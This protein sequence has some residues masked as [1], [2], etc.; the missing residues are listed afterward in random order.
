LPAG[1]EPSGR[2]AASA[3]ELE[4]GRLRP[5]ENRSGARIGALI[6]TEPARAPRQSRESTIATAL[7]R[8][9]FEPAEYTARATPAAS[10]VGSP[11]PTRVVFFVAKAGN[12]RST[13][14]WL[15]LPLAPL[16]GVLVFESPLRPQPPAASASAS[17]QAAARA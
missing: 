11:P 14:A 2:S 15:S 17:R 4:A 12:P 16:V 1:R 6:S 13:A 10:A 8:V 9:T 7:G 3:A 5:S